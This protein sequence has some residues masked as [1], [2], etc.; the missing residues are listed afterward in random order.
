MSR[1]DIKNQ[2][3]VILLLLG[4]FTCFW[5]HANAKPISLSND[6]ETFL[7]IDDYRVFKDSSAKFTIEQV[8]E[9]PDTMFRFDPKKY[10]INQDQVLWLKLEVEASGNPDKLW[11]LELFNQRA[12]EVTLFAQIEDS[13]YV[14]L[15]TVGIDL[16]FYNRN[17]HNRFPAFEIPMNAG[18]NV[19]YLK[20][21]SRYHLGTNTLIRPYYLYTNY[22]NAYYFIIG[23]FYFVLLILIL[24][25]FLFFLS[26]WDRI[27]IY[28][29]LF[30]ISAGLDCLRVDN[31]G[32]AILWPNHP[33]VNNY[34][35]EVTRPF[36]IFCSINYAS[37]FLSIK[38]EHPKIFRGL[39]SVFGLYII[40][41]TLSTILKAP[42]VV[43][44]YITEVL[45]FSML[46]LVLY[47]AL[48]R[49]MMGQRHIRIFM[50]GY[51]SMVL[52]FVVTYMFYNGWISGNMFVYYAL[53]YG[54]CV[55]T[56]M[57]SFALSARLRYERQEKERALKAENEVR[58]KV[59]EQMQQ[60]E[61]LLSKVN[62]ELEERVRERTM[63]IEA[64][65]L[66]LA[67]Q[68]QLIKN[69]NVQ[70]DKENWNLNKTIKN[71]KI[72]KVIPEDQTYAQI[73]EHFASETDCY[74]FIADLKW[75]KGYQC[76]KCGNTKESK[77]NDF[78]TRRCSKCGDVES[79]TADTIFHKL[80]FPID[81][82]FYI[83][84]LV[85]TSKKPINISD[86]EREVDLNYRTCQKFKLKIEEALASKE[87]QGKPPK[88]W[89][90][91]IIET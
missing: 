50:V 48:R 34:I 2:F 83:A 49:L 5:N 54:I 46:F 19:F 8:S 11:V 61:Q 57:F 33:E 72:R 14:A 76:R 64:S 26:T 3:L 18:K 67:E 38:K 78:Y 17:L 31:I 65:K 9:L 21:R 55:D 7:S 81:K 25:N 36:F 27:Y 53:F 86:L 79:I 52:G 51:V 41:H 74:Q 42:A 70:L 4:S 35:D 15:D 87:K 6:K 56:F 13:G 37:Y 69:L 85:F 32:F 24:Y 84:Y 58:L 63:E 1:G 80:K 60:N 71:L 59:I 62:R 45:M 66:Q 47:V 90:D 77:T 20:Y 16:P 88:S 10:F 44:L 75:N 22:S 82:A 23:G 30:V 43:S 40:Q 28:Y 89:E 29:I 39:W 12:A 68:A 91:L 73:K